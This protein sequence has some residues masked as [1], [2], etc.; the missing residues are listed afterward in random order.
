MLKKNIDRKTQND[1]SRPNYKGCG[2]T[3][4]T[5]ESEKKQRIEKSGEL[6]EKLDGPESHNNYMK[7][8]Q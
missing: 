3:R 6:G 5:L 7:K 2:I 4:W 8:K 1:M